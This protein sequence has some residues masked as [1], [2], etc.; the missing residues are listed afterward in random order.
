MLLQRRLDRP[1]K[2]ALNF[3]WVIQRCV[4]VYIKLISPFL[5]ASYILIYLSFKSVS[6]F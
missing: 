1:P 3:L 2:T 5:R 4:C 6:G